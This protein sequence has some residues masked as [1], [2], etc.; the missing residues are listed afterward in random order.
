MADEQPK[1]IVDEDWKA[2]VQREKEE[3]AKK[4]QAQQEA[5]ERDGGAAPHPPEEASFAALVQTLA[6]QCAFALGLIAQR[7]AK[8]VMVDIV[9]AKYMIDT[10]MMLR[11]K[12]KGNLTPKE[13]GVLANTIAD[14]QQAYVMRSQQVQ[15][16]ALK[17]A[18]I[19]LA[20]PDKK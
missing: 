14:L 8:Q 17:Q 18:G 7:D 10:L 1:I 19:D 6:M 15:E 11:T 20:K 9:E 5:P 2:Q 16:A 13:E 12:T 4:A 3:A